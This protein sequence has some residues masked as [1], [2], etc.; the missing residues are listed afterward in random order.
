LWSHLSEPRAEAQMSRVET[1]STTSALA[2]S[3]EDARDRQQQSTFSE[4][5]HANFFTNHVDMHEQIEGDVLQHLK[6]N[7]AVSEA[8]S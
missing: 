7:S 1:A 5:S 6:T 4:P 2:G 8:F 3:G